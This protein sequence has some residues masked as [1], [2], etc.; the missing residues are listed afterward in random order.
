MNTTHSPAGPGAS[1]LAR[2]MAGVAGA[3][4]VITVLTLLARTAGFLRWFALNAWVGP[5]AVG[6]AYQTANT[7]PNLLFEVTAGGALAGAVVPLL[8]APIAARMRAD[9]DAIASALL[10]WSLAVLVP[11]AVLTWAAAPLFVG[12]LLPGSAAS[13][14]DLAV[15]LLRIFAWQIPLYGVAVVLSGVLQAH[16]RF[17]GPAIAPLASSVVVMASYAVFARLTPDG[18]TP[19]S[20]SAQAVAVLGWGTTA[21]VVALSLPLLIPVRAAGVRLRPTLRFPDGLA[22]RARSLA[23]AG[24]GGLLAQQLAIVVTVRLANSHG[25]PGALTIQTYANAV[26]LLPYAVLAIPV[27]TAMFPRL[28]EHAALRQRD[29]LAQRTAVS[30]RGITIIAAVGAAAL[31]AAAG[32]VQHV[33]EEFA[34]EGSVVG[35]AGGVALGAPSVLGLA[36]MYHLTR[37]LFALERS[38]LAL[39][40]TSAGWI[41]VALAAVVLAGVFVPHGQDAAGVLRALG[42]AASI[43]SLIGAATL[44]WAVRH[45]LGAQAVHGLVRTLAVS[46]PA[47]VLGAVAGAGLARLVPHPSAVAAVGIGVGVG[48]LAAAIVVTVVATADRA[49]WRVLRAALPGPGGRS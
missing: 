23:F 40:G 26:V 25:G 36:V 2:L 5:N 31:A 18:V 7:V 44:G 16:R 43:G 45:E 30:T 47:A 3:A 4:A 27:A 13:D 37:V 12:A 35:M 48:A 1:R 17:I 49:T 38:R 19:G 6:S 46:V 32:P 22:G 20:L 41:G 28:A 29:L 9:V 33:F 39:I 8:A 14:L 11:V 21:G 42:L 34:R 15:A 10:G 24:A